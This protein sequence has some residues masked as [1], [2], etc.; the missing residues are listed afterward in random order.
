VAARAAAGELGAEFV[1]EVS[2]ADAGEGGGGSFT[3]VP[4]THDG[5]LLG[6]VANVVGDGLVGVGLAEGDG[7]PVAE[8]VEVFPVACAVAGAG[9]RAHIGRV[10]R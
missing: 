2:G 7:V 3:V 1:A 6:C 4:D 9:E 10:T 5:R 8:N